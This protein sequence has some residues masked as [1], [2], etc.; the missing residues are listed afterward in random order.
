[1]ESNSD[2]QSTTQ[3]DLYMYLLLKISGIVTSSLEA[4]DVLDGVLW[5]IS[6]GI[7]IDTCWINIYDPAENTLVLSASKD[8]SKEIFDEIKNIPPTESI[9]GHVSL[10]REYSIIADLTRETEFPWQ[11]AVKAGYCSM[12]V[13]PILSRGHSLGIIGLMSFNTNKF[14]KNHANLLSII[15]NMIADTCNTSKIRSR[16]RETKK[17][18]EEIRQIQ[19][20]LNIIGHELKTPLTAIL[21]SVGLLTEELMKR[22]ENLLIKI[23]NN[24]SRSASSL[25]DRLQDMLDISH[26]QTSVFSISKSDFD[27]S[28]FIRE[29]SEQLTTII[30][31]K[32]Q[33]L[34]FDLPESLIVNA[35]QQRLEQILLNLISNA[36]KFTPENGQISIMA[37]KENNNLIISVKDSGTD[38]PPDERAKLFQPYYRL[39]ADRHRVPG[40]GLGLTITKQLVELHGGRIWID[41]EQGAG[42]TFSFTIPLNI[43]NQN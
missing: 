29:V 43:N 24:I 16:A 32:K 21:S 18:Y 27:L 20:Y 33:T 4:E 28:P 41:S 25:N 11:N 37:K 17:Q 15:G 9:F 35:D 14:N 7:N 38:I 19:Q 31:Q 1:M 5:E 6:N 36:T 12:I 22:N 40:L 30:E 23:A 13:S 39:I 42:N 2:K 3:N 34:T 26:F 10:N 8:I